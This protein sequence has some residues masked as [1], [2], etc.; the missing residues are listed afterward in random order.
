MKKKKKNKRHQRKQNKTK[1][2]QRNCQKSNQF[3][4]YYHQRKKITMK[5]LLKRRPHPKKLMSGLTLT[6]LLKKNQNSL[7]KPPKMVKKLKRKIK[8]MKRMK[9]LTKEEKR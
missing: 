9:K 3:I 2:Y 6:M 4:N 8:K 1:Y 7:K 5:F